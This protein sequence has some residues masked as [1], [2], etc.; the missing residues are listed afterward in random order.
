MSTYRYIVNLSAND[1]AVHLYQDEEDNHC[2]VWGMESDDDPP[3]DP[4]EAAAQ[5][6]CLPPR[7]I[8]RDRDVL[9][10]NGSMHE[11]LHCAIYFVDDGKGIRAL[12]TS[13]QVADTLTRNFVPLKMRVADQDLFDDLMRIRHA[14][15][16]APEGT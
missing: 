2:L 12:N 6:L 14:A 3:K 7:R 1:N 4:E 10:R 5:G 13:L 9:V 16:L 11:M 15:F 8:D